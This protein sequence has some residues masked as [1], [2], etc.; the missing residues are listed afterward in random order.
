MWDYTNAYSSKLPVSLDIG[1]KATFLLKSNK[2]SFLSV[3]PTHVGVTDSFGRFHWV[4]PASLRATK[5]EYFAKYSE[6]AW[7]FSR[8]ES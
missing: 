3:N 6:N 8:E 2:D 7:G 1:E 4:S 5:S